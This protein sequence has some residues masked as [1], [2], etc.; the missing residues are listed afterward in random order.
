M[1]EPKTPQQE[2]AVLDYMLKHNQSHAAELDRLAGQIEANGHAEA[3]QQLKKASD[4]MM[5]SNLYLSLA[6]SLVKEQQ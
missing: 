3:A 6:L 2:Y 4:E 1:P 5:K